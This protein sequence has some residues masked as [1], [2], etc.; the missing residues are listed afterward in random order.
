MSHNSS[1]IEEKRRAITV[2]GLSGLGNLGNTCYMNAVLQCL[3]A[4]D[5]F[6]MYIRERH[7]KD[8]LRTGTIESLAEEKRRR[9]KLGKDDEVVLKS[10]NIKKHFKDSITYRL[11]QVLATMWSFNCTVRP[12]K[13]KELVGKK[14]DTFKGYS[15][16]DSQ[17]LLNFLLDR[18]HE[19]T[20]T[21]VDLEFCD[22]PESV[23]VY[24]QMKQKY[25]AQLENPDITDDEKLKIM[26]AYNEYKVDKS[27]EDAIYKS[28]QYWKSYL[29]G[30]HS[31]IIDIF[32]GLYFTEIE[33]LTCNNKT[34]TFEPFNMLQVAIPESSSAHSNTSIEECLDGVTKSE[35]LT[36][37][38]QYLCDVCRKKTDA[39]KRTYI[40][41]T[42]ERLIIH[43]K[44]FKN[45]GFHTMKID[46]F[47]SYPLTGLS[48]SGNMAPYAK[49][50]VTYD[51]YG[52]VHHSGSLMGGH[53]IAYTKN[54]IN[55]L[56]YEFN[57]DDVVH[58]EP[59]EV[60]PEVV[61]RGAYILF[62]KKSRPIV[63]DFGDDISV[64]SDDTVIEPNK[65]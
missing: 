16:N 10:G 25:N 19:E 27:T 5:V 60:D 51:L 53:Y 9:D 54:P 36:G 8:D 65:C 6:S 58:V 35:H 31:R 22:V 14:C 17:E 33:C 64:G 32:T 56:W 23:R 48:L 24:Q 55:N 46:K 57:D 11:Y 52:V 41:N 40:W 49:K 7:F 47:I 21:D 30:N 45:N 13:F 26:M 34:F 29:K 28:F 38:N 43:L 12:R 42:P 59:K 63:E 20:K 62:Y 18:I 4:T 1:E 15:Q 2:R 44:R 61:S 50:D 37:D 39:E 3:M